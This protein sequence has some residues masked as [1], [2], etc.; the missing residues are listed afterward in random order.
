MGK[1]GSEWMMTH[2]RTAGI[3]GTARR[4]GRG[5]WRPPRAAGC[6][7]RGRWPEGGGQRGE[8]GQTFIQQKRNLLPRRRGAEGNEEQTAP[9]PAG[10]WP[11]AR[12]GG[13]W[14]A[15]AGN[16]ERL[17]RNYMRTG[18]LLAALWG[19]MG[20]RVWRVGGAKP[21]AGVRLPRGGA[22]RWTSRSVGRRGPQG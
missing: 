21:A 16:R 14:G 7:A 11:T 6:S 13:R 15:A 3:P 22:A 9:V 12:S 20:E 10:R 2:R 1:W 4:W 5:E 19:R 8:A 18:L 17:N